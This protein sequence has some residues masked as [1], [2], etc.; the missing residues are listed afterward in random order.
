VE[1]FVR[2][3]RYGL[4]TL[5]R[6]P[7]LAAA[8]LVS[9]VLGIGLVTTIF[10]VVDAV[11]VRPLQYAEPGRLAIVWRTRADRP[12]DTVTPADFL[13]WREQSRAFEQLAG[14]SYVS[15]N[16]SGEGAPERARGA[17]VSRNFFD[18]LGVRPAIG[19][20][21]AASAEGARE[22][23]LGDAL[24]RRR[25]GADPGVVGRTVL[26]HGE[27]YEVVA[28]MPPDFSWP[29]V[30]PSAALAGEEVDFWIRAPYGDV[31]QLGASIDP[32]LPA[33]RNRSFL[34]VVGRLRPGV[35]VGEAE[36]EMRTIAERLGAQYPDSNAGRGARVVDLHT[37]F[38]GDVRLPLYVLLVAGLFVLAI[39]A[40]NVANLLL[41]H[42]LGRRREMAV[43]AALGAGRW[44]LA[45][46][47]LTESG[48]LAVLAAAGGALVAVWGVPALV[49]L[50]P[51]E[52][53]RLDGVSVDAGAL[54]FTLV[55]A[56]ATALAVGLVPAFQ[57]SRGDLVEA[58]KAEGRGY[59]GRSRARSAFVVSGVALALVLLVSA[60]LL[61]ESFLR[62][63]RVD[64]GFD[65]SR[66]LAL[67]LSLPSSYETPE[68][69]IAFFSRA[70]ERIEAIPGVERAGTVLNVPLGGDDI[71]FP[72]RFEGRSDPPTAETPTVGYQ[73]ASPGYFAAL[74]VPVRE[75]RGF[76][77]EDRAGAMPV[78]AVNETTARRF[79]PEGGAVGSR[80]RLG[81]NE[82][83]LTVVGVVA[84][85][86]HG[87]LD[88]EPRAEAYVSSLQ[89]SFSFTDV[90]VRAKGDPASLAPAVRSA[91]AEV[92]AAQP[93]ANV[94]TMEEA[95]SAAVADRR[96][97][98]LLVTLFGLTALGLAAVGIYGVVAYTVVQRTRDIGIRMAL[99]AT[100][101]DVVSLVVGEGLRLALVG[102]ALG[103]AGALAASRL[104]SGLLY[105]VSSTDPLAYAGVAATVVAVAALAA[106]LPARR[107]SRLD[108][109]DVL[110]E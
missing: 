61:L 103:L 98:S 42:A 57:A 14:F 109:A 102:T 73:I 59:S 63:R 29:L 65:G 8:A 24:W 79:W 1:S 43:R 90:V 89:R 54:A 20:A 76:L 30:T 94:R 9:L 18:L 78:A 67:T 52:V 13:E 31:P 110:R 84:D 22:V 80:I 64:P 34:R 105:E 85:V 7:A 26:L 27:S 12:L 77:P 45:R 88:A 70:L 33:S 69:Q 82:E 91:V 15:L 83:W 36:A 10:T 95:L 101:R 100:R 49:R 5:A 41:A 39:A 104:L 47:T 38:V 53:P 56:L 35:S 16:L 28:V 37:Q 21:F 40:T 44:R 2:D 81:G 75:G 60:G 106:Y 50:S 51:A 3:A 19:R 25:F 108:P 6:R 92:D 46:Q 93:V 66:V 99:G 32:T 17:S 72:I 74:G 4:R 11:L 87:G 58:L 97:T 68:Q 62:L 86:R 107:A 96:F 71:S 23:V 48:V 55:V